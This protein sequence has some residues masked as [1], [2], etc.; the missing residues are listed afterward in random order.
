MELAVPAPGT[1]LDDRYRVLRPIGGGGMGAV[2]AVEHIALGRQVALKAMLP[3]LASDP[4]YASRFMREARIASAV[5]SEHV[6]RV[7]DFGRLADGTLFM[8]MELLGG[9]DLE[10]EIKQRGP[11]AVAEAARVVIEACDAIAEAHARGIVHRDLKPA[12][13]FLAQGQGAQRSVKVLD[14]GISKVPRLSQGLGDAEL[15][16]TDSTLGSPKYMSPEQLR[17]PKHVDHRSDIWSLGVVLY[18]SLSGKLPFSAESIGGYITEVLTAAP[19]P[20][21]QEVPADLARAVYRCLAKDPA[22]RYPS[23]L[24]LV[25]ALAPFAPEAAAHVAARLG[26]LSPTIV[27]DE[28]MPPSVSGAETVAITKASRPMDGRG[29]AAAV[30]VVAVVVCG[31]AALSFF[32]GR[33]GQTPAVPAHETRASA[34]EGAATATSTAVIAPTPVGSAVTSAVGTEAIAATTIAPSTSAPSATKEG[35]SRAEGGRS[36][37][38]RSNAPPPPPPPTPSGR[39]PLSRPAVGPLESAL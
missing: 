36:T 18:R 25:R 38:V 24:A 13:L 29:R 33:R 35:T 19:I 8:T 21:G 37:V 14:F 23:A 4:E 5:S 28:T 12:N 20:L 26:T 15:T 16:T 22:H 10:Q 2:F 11:L 6:P 7:F 30:G 39:P 27:D 9:C 3:K 1:V 34:T 32:V 17:S 31:A